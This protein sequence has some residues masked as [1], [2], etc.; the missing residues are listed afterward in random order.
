MG[1][2]V[3]RLASKAHRQGDDR[4]N[5]YCLSFRNSCKLTSN[6]VFNNP[7]LAP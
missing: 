4:K 5:T 6:T 1:G 2:T 7:M 3:E